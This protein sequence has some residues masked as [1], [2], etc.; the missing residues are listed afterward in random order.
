MRCTTY[1]YEVDEVYFMTKTTTIR[2]G[3]TTWE[4][5]NSRRSVG[6]S[7]DDVLNIILDTVEETDKGAIND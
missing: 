7:F 5:L 2:V 4:R 3:T 6:Q 1:I